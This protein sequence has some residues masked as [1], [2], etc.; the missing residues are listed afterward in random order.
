M[1]KEILHLN[2]PSIKV[3]YIQFYCIVNKQ[4]AKYTF[5]LGNDE[6]TLALIARGA[7]FYH[8]YENWGTAYFGCVTRNGKIDLKENLSV[9]SS[10][11]LNLLKF[12]YLNK[13]YS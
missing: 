13:S 7:D 11:D 10:N 6:I 2:L 5:I 8:L 1:A 9:Y 4:T 12:S 3:I